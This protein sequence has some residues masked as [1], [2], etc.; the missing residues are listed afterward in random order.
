[1]KR[2]LIRPLCLLAVVLCSFGLVTAQVTSQSRI[3]V[4]AEAAITGYR[5]YRQGDR[6]YVIILSPVSAAT[7]TSLQAGGFEDLQVSQQGQDLSISF[8]LEP[9][10]SAAVQQKANVIEIAIQG[11]TQPQVAATDFSGSDLVGGGQARNEA[12]SSASELRSDASLVT[13][14]SGTTTN[15]G[16]S[17]TR[18]DAA[19]ATP[20][21]NTDEIQKKNKLTVV[22]DED[23]AVPESPAFTVLGLTPQTVI[24]PATPKEFVS[25]LLNGLDEHG[26]VQT[27]LAFDAVPFLV[28][29][30]DTI[31]LYDYNHSYLTRVLSRTQT[32]FAT[33][34]GTGDKDKSV[35][36]A[37]G[38][39]MTLWDRGDPRTDKELFKC[40]D[41]VEQ[42]I[43]KDVVDFMINKGVKDPGFA[44]FL[45][46][47][48][49][50]FKTVTDQC[51]VEA[52]ERNWK[53]SA[54]V[55]GAAPSWISPTGT[56]DNFRW[57]GGGVWASL[58]YGF[59]GLTG[60]QRN[61]QLIFHARFRSNEQVPYPD[62]AGN[63]FTQK[64]SFVGSRLRL[65]DPDTNLSFE[66]VYI[67][68]KRPGQAW[69]NS[70]RFLAGLERRVA[71]NIWFQL[72]VGK[73][74]GR[75]DGNNKAFIKGTFNWG[76]VRKNDPVSPSVAD[77]PKP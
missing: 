46:E 11:S 43:N 75:G 55:I 22:N 39:H 47:Q 62:H 52:R 35:R 18:S 59:D 38:L 53:S 37:L 33:T 24:R 19:V 48:K 76:F 56:S 74:S 45:A 67:R 9:G 27:G 1:M 26:N 70:Y 72:S 34:K 29:G 60:L 8:R 58:A 49:T 57:N 64:S 17:G 66:G 28:F 30:G 14:A 32:S 21:S 50:R 10:K 54:I 5:S 12:E 41:R 20:I 77:L 3:R 69:D 4:T 16:T 40:Y 42:Q 68:L 25:S 13:P 23:L 7:D 61:S 2:K 36:L 73:D 6:L 31:S 51:D 71:Q 15:S 44:S 65:G 63:F